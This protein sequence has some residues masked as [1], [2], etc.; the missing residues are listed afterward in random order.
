[1]SELKLPPNPVHPPIVSASVGWHVAMLAAAVAQ[2]AWWPVWLGGVAANHL[3]LCAASMWP[4]STLLGPNIRQLPPSAASAGHVCITIDDGPDPEITPRVLQMLADANARASFFCIGD[5]VDQYPA[6]VEQIVAQGHS[7]ENHT[8]THHHRFAFRGKSGLHTEIA[9]AQKSIANVAGQA[10]RFFRAPAGMR[11][12]FLQPVLASLGLCLTSW[13]RRGF[14]TVERSPDKVFAR[15]TRQLA[16]G[17]ILL[18]H[19][20]HGAHTS[21]GSSVVLEALPRLLAEVSA[22]ELRPV[23]LPQAFAP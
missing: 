5:K 6:L 7:V 9:S 19:D 18:I 10:P 15:L 2:P 3:G 8:Q 17:D 23:T 14:D 13:T 21:Q 1:M 16:A 4:R 11:N 20:G 12:P 22:R